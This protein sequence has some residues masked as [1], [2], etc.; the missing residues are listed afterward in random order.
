MSSLEHILLWWSADSIRAASVNISFWFYSEVASQGSE[1][2]H[3]LQSLSHTNAPHSKRLYLLAAAFIRYTGGKFNSSSSKQHTPPSWQ[4][5]VPHR[6]ENKWLGG[7]PQNEYRGRWWM[8][9]TKYNWDSVVDGSESWWCRL[10][11]FIFTVRVGWVG[12]QEIERNDIAL[13]QSAPQTSLPMSS[14]TQCI[15]NVLCALS[16]LPVIFFF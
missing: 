1:E 14:G 16:L 13:W 3:I 5:R 6:Q 8:N 11:L 4:N 10:C 7:D 12:S 2:S 15:W 9:K